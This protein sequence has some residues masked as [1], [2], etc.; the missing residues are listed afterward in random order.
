[1]KPSLSLILPVHNA[2]RTLA[3]DIGRL[4]DVLPD[5]ARKFEILVVDRG[6]SDQTLE[7]AQDLAMEF[8]QIRV[9]VEPDADALPRVMRH[10]RGET[11][12]AHDGDSTIDAE[13]LSCV[14]RAPAQRSNAWRRAARSPG[15]SNR[16]PANAARTDFRCS[17]RKRCC[18]CVTTPT[19]GRSNVGSNR[20][21]PR[22]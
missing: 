12:I 21:P 2:Q 8:P 4:L 10:I 19:P 7:V 1:M 9:A 3:A 16:P 5:L 6:S 13:Q 17:T 14:C 15:D 18:G 11:V 20:S 22:H